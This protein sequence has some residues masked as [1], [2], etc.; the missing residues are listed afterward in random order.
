MAIYQKIINTKAPTAVILIRLIVGAVF[1]SEGLQKLLFASELSAGR[2]AKI[3]ISKPEFF[4]P[5]IGAFEILCGTLI[6]LGLFTR[7]ALAPLLIIISGAIAMT[8]IA[9]LPEKGFWVTS[10]D[11][12]TTTLYS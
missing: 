3:G 7:L 12:R 10:H 8:K 11:G 2:F 1:L 5:F 9:T 4:G 6:L